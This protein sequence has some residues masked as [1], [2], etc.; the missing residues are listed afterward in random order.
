MTLFRLKNI[1]L[2]DFFSNG[3]LTYAHL[4]SNAVAISELKSTGNSVSVFDSNYYI[5][6]LILF[7][8]NNDVHNISADVF[9]NLAKH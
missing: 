1:K 4:R 2:K 5:N 7:P 9:K 8:R 6:K 3:D